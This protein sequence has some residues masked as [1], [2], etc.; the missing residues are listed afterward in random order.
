MSG[1]S[2]LAVVWRLTGKPEGRGLCDHCPRR[3]THRYEITSSASQVM[4]VGACCLRV[5]TGWT[6]TPAEAES[7]LKWRKVTARREAN[8]SAFAAAHPDEAAAIDA[9]IAAFTDMYPGRS[10]QAGASG[11][12]RYQVEKH[13]TAAAD[14]VAAYM[15]RRATLKWAA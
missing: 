2:E 4:T 1:T 5:I 14:L 9:D 7:Q 10:G 8:W 13:G 12:V 6:I 3:L 15:T 11:E